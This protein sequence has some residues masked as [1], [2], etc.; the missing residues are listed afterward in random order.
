MQRSPTAKPLD[1]FIHLTEDKDQRRQTFLQL[2]GPKIAE[3][4]RFVE[5]RTSICFSH[6]QLRTDLTVEGDY[7][8]TKFDVTQFEGINTIQQVYEAVLYAMGNMDTCISEEFGHIAFVKTM[9][10]WIIAFS[11]SGWS[12]ATTMA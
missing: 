5:D 1:T 4:R 10:A 3:A 11:T 7:F 12:R 6:I 9:T 8:C 2:R